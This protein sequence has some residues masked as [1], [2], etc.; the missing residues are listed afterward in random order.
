MVHCTG[1]CVCGSLYMSVCVAYR[2][3]L[4]VWFIVFVHGSL[5]RPLCVVY[6]LL[7]GL[8]VIHRPENVC[9]SLYRSVCVVHSTSLRVWF[10]LQACVCGSLYRTV[11]VVHCTYLY[12]WFIV[13]VCVWRAANHLLRINWPRTWVSS[14]ACAAVSPTGWCLSEPKSGPNWASRWLFR[15]LTLCLSVWVSV[16][17]PSETSLDW[18]EYLSQ[19]QDAT[20]ALPCHI[21]LPVCLWI[22]D[23]YNRAPKKN[24]SHGNEVLPQDTTHLI[25]RPC[26]QRGS[27]CQDPAGNQ[28]TGRPPDHGKESQTAVVW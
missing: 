23:P 5:Y 10:T 15:S 24:T 8:R 9:G 6:L 20:D 22:M 21:Y 12:V 2:T 4:W 19:L 28:T 7:L 14:S 27:P 13:Q 25:Q 11:Y 18:Q 26:Y 17:L 1:L 3:G 16:S